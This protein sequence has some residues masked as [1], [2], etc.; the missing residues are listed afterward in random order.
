MHDCLV[1]RET[2]CLIKCTSSDAKPDIPWFHGISGF[3]AE[4]VLQYLL[5]LCNKLESFAFAIGLQS[6][7]VKYATF[8]LPVIF[9][10]TCPLFA[11]KIAQF[12]CQIE[13]LI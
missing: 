6:C 7:G 11:I 8:P 4:E 1:K 12:V 10:K 2:Y 3:A 5:I 9:S 13:K